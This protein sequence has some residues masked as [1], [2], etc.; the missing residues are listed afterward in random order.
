MPILHSPGLMMPGQF[1]PMS[2]VADC[3]SRWYL[4]STM[5]CCGTPSVMATTN[6]ISFSIASKIAA[7]QNG[8][9]T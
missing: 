1:G 6:P 8:G 5:S 7:L 4:T 3:L 2:L 9:G